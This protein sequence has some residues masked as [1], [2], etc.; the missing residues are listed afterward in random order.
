MSSH[1]LLKNVLSGIIYHDYEFYNIFKLIVD[2]SLTTK[3]KTSRICRLYHLNPINYEV[4]F[5]SVY[6]SRTPLKNIPLFIFDHCLKHILSTNKFQPFTVESNYEGYIKFNCML[7]Y[8]SFRIELLPSDFFLWTLVLINI[9]TSDGRIVLI[10]LPVAEEE[11][12]NVLT[13]QGFN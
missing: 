4:L 2:L 8:V 10:Y 6:I 1:F 7:L 12:T 9:A 5:V 11:P 3:Y 13:E